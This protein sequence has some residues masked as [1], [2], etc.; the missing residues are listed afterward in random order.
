MLKKLN[1]R[2]RNPKCHRASTM[3]SVNSNKNVDFKTS[4]YEPE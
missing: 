3:Q 2:N 1:I 4:K